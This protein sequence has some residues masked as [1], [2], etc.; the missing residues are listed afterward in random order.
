MG[1]A[2]SQ[3]RLLTL[4]ARI[5]DVEWEAQCI[6]NSKLQLATQE[7]QVYKEYLEALDA[8]TLTVK[9]YEG[10]RI[11]ATFN[12][13]C[14]R[15]AVDSA[16]KYAL[17]DSEGAL[18]VSDE[19]ADAYEQYGN[20]GSAY[21]FAFAVLGLSG[22]G[23]NMNKLAAQSYIDH[24]GESSST[25]NRMTEIYKSMAEI[26]N[27]A[28]ISNNILSNGEVNITSVSDYYT[29]IS[30]LGGEL[31]NSEKATASDKS[32]YKALEK[33]LQELAFNSFPD[34]M[35]SNASLASDKNCS[36]SNKNTLEQ[37]K[38]DI[39]YYVSIYNQIKASNGYTRISDYNG[40][41]GDAANN[42][43]WLQNMIKSGKITIYTVGED[44][45]GNTQLNGTGVASD[46]Y[47]EYTTTSTIDKSK[48]AQ[49]EAEYEHKTKEIQRKDKRYDM[50]LTKLE[51]ERKALTTQYDAVKKVISEN[52]D[53]TYD[54]FNS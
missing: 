23:V 37:Y 21:L 49:V 46:T 42:A 36:I 19:V 6:Q 31:D 39:D 33:E 7:D 41:F 24:K 14:G 12:T 4:T 11:T 40:S 22:N 34:E 26:L 5:H 8:T 50:S 17:K 48:L 16:N 27:K 9:D 51:T 53:R 1:M 3:A 30:Y 52:I 35:I 32:S 38:G 2:A 18:I 10:N 15:N 28:G 29:D 45:E 13:L 20:A 25:I 44:A 47:L 43:E 54:I